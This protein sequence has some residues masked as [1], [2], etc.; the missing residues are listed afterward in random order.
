TAL[1]QSESINQLTG[2]QIFF[3]CENFQKVGAFKMRGALFA[4]QQLSEEEKANGVVT[5]SSG[6]HAQAVARAAKQLGIKAYIVMPENAP[7]IK[8][9]AVKNYG[10][11][12]SFCPHNLEARESGMKKIQAE[13]AATVI[14]PYDHFNI[15][16]GQATAA[17]ELIEDTQEL[18]AI[19]CPVSG[20]GLLAGSALAANYFGKCKVYGTEPSA[21]D[22]AYRSFH[23]GELIPQ[24]N[25]QTIADGLRTSL[26][27]LNFAII[28]K[29]VHDILI[30]EEY[31]IIE[32]MRLIW[33]RMKIIVEPSAAVPLAAVLNNKAV[34]VNQKVGMIISGGNVD[35]D[36]Y[37][38][39]LSVDIQ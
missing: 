1:L 27:E 18:D 17:K 11:V 3:K 13:T 23:A 21:A 37:L 12:I 38:N 36:A 10:G 31:Q 32:A 26:G 5:H 2:C 24:N 39:K 30:V 20:G 4:L 28:K 22:D 25:P 34:F 8:V 33:E 16:C 35:L 6:N 19:L 7:K 14:P 15:I 9:N 29:Y